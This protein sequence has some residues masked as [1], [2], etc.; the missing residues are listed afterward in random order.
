MGIYDQHGN[1]YVKYNGNP[2]TSEGTQT[3]IPMP[4]DDDDSLA[5]SFGDASPIGS[6]DPQRSP[7]VLLD[8]RSGIDDQGCQSRLDQASKRNCDPVTF[9]QQMCDA[10]SGNVP[11]ALVTK[12]IQLVQRDYQQGGRSRKRLMDMLPLAFS[13]AAVPIVFYALDLAVG[14]VGRTWM[15]GCWTTTPSFLT[16][17]VKM[18]FSR[19]VFTT[20][21][22]LITITND[23]KIAPV[24]GYL[25]VPPVR[26]DGPEPLI[27]GQG[28]QTLNMH[29]R[30][31]TGAVALPWFYRSQLSMDTAQAE[32]GRAVPITPAPTNAYF[33][34]LT[35]A[36]PAAPFFGFS[37][38]V[39]SATELSSV[40]ISPLCNNHRDMIEVVPILMGVG[41]V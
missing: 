5:V 7:P 9:V 1:P 11:V 20:T 18:V 15:V 14:G 8:F 13:G 19:T 40:R 24:A 37:F 16:F 3:V 6:I 36:A 35:P 39:Q 33:Q 41:R 30:K 21:E 28:G 34:S 22:S 38:L 26:Y 4:M 29:L 17:G 32:I 31:P 25:P 12:G 27:R 23:P 10:L 2:N